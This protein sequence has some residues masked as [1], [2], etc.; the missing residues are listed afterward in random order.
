MKV[1][2]LEAV[3]PLFSRFIKLLQPIN[4]IVVPYQ[5]KDFPYRYLHLCCTYKHETSPFFCLHSDKFH[6]GVCHISFIALKT[7]KN[8]LSQAADNY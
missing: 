3:I 1:I 8:N 6:C 5:E 4:D 7:A 2:N